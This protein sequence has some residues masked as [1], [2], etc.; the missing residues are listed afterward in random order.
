MLF[1][2][3]ERYTSLI[4]GDLAAIWSI[5]GLALLG[6]PLS[7]KVYGGYLKYVAEQHVTIWT[8]REEF[9]NATLIMW[10]SHHV[11][12]YTGK[13]VIVLPTAD[14]VQVELDQQSDQT[15]RK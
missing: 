13:K 7:G 6:V 11:A 15:T 10:F 14:V 5:V 2:L 1:L 9:S 3:L 4:S 12:F 8:K